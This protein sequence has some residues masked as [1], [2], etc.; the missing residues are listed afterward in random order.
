MKKKTLY[1]LYQ[2]KQAALS[3]GSFFSMSERDKEMHWSKLRAAKSIL[4]L[5]DT[6]INQF[7]QLGMIDGQFL[8]EEFL[9]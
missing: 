5:A 2:K 3:M 1:V 4:F 7:L 6:L 8:I 9:S